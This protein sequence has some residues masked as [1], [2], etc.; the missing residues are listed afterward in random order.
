MKRR[1]FLSRAAAILAAALL[2]LALVP[3]ASVDAS[4]KHGPL[5]GFKHLVVIYEE[6]HSFDNLYGNWGSVGGKHV[7]GRSDA[8]SARTTQVAQVGSTYDCLLMTDVNLMSPAAG[9]EVQHVDVHLH[10]TARRRPIRLGN[11]PFNIDRYIPAT[12]TTCPDEDHL[13]SFPFGLLNGTG[14]PGGCTRDLVHRFYQEQYQLDGGKQDRYVT[15][16]DS[17]GM[18]MGYYNTKE[19]PIYEYLHSR[20]GAALRRPRP[21]LPGGVRRLVP[22][23]PV[24]GRRRG[25]AVPDRHPLRPRRER[26][27]ERELPALPHDRRRRRSG[28]PG[29]RPVDHGRRVRLRRLRGQH[30]PAVLPADERVRRPDARGRRHHH[31]AHDRRHAERRRGQLELVLGWLGQ[32]RRQ[33]RRSRLHERRGAGVR[34]PELRPGGPRRSG[35]RRLSVLPGQV[36]P[37][38]PPAAQ[39]LRP[40]RARPAGSSAPQGRAGLPLGGPPWPAP[41]GELRQAARQRERAPRLHERA[42]WQRPSRRPDQGNPARSAGEEHADRG[43]LRRVRRAVGPRLAARTRDDGRAPARPTCSGPAR[44]SRPS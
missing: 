37:D 12:A 39:L 2:A 22:Q 24:P 32:R 25:S 43:H 8:T 31:A 44:A 19:L 33:R 20:H 30:G 26:L 13:F 7:V 40:L 41:V 5:D 34:R 27:P 1:P 14:L 11:R 28:D 21:L 4:S 3:A 15:G 38:P 36:L 16:S 10:A 17:A 42:E 9:A 6:N 35:Q 18:T 29:L 23:P